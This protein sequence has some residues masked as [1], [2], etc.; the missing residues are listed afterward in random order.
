MK[1]K[2][3]EAWAEWEKNNQSDYGKACVDVARRVMEILDEGKDFDPYQII[4]QADEDI[5]AGGITGRN[6]RQAIFIYEAAR[7]E[8]EISNRPIVPEPWSARDEA[9]LCTVCEGSRKANVGGQVSKRRGGT[10]FVVARI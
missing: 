9:F 3:K 10:R 6:L 7:L 1:L 5:Q 4:C 8:A 2:D